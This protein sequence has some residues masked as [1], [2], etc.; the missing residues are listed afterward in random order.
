MQKK[1]LEVSVTCRH[2]CK[3][4]KQNISQPY[5]VIYI[6]NDIPWSIWEFPWR[7]SMLDFIVYNDVRAYGLQKLG[8]KTIDSWTK[9]E[10]WKCSTRYKIMKWKIKHP[11]QKEMRETHLFILNIDGSEWFGAW[12]H[13]ICVF[14]KTQ[15]KISSN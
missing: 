14:R 13:D 4:P 1:I 6:R 15:A 8:T 11:L 9:Q 12:I 10:F 7:P 2:E 3:N 5:P